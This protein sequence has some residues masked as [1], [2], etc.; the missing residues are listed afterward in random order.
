VNDRKQPALDIPLTDPGF[1]SVENVSPVIE[2]EMGDGRQTTKAFGRGILR[3]HGK[4]LV[5]LQQFLDPILSGGL[6]WG[7]FSLSRSPVSISREL[8]PAAILVMALTAFHL[9]K[10]KVYLSYRQRSLRT[11]LRRITE[12]WINVIACLLLIAFLAK[13][14]T[15]WSRIYFATWALLGWLLM[16]TVHVGSHKGLRLLRSRGGNSRTVLFWGSK[17]SAIEFHNELLSLPYLGLKMTAWFSPEDFVASTSLPQGMPACLGGIKEIENWL[18]TNDVDQIHFN[19]SAEL[20]GSIETLVRIFGNT[21]KP[22]FYMPSWTHPAMNFSIDQLNDKFLIGLWGKD[23]SMLELKLKRVCDIIAS[24]LLIALLSPLLVMLGGMTKL[25]SPGPVLYC[26]DRY[27]LDGHPFKIYKFRTM[28]V[29]EC[30]STMN[31]QQARKNDPRV[32]PVGR[33]M[34]KWSLDELPQLF[35]VLNGSMSLV[36]PRPHAVA[37]NEQ[38]RNQITGYMQRHLFRPGITGLAQVQGFRGETPQLE[39]MI[40]RVEADLYYLKEWSIPLDLRVLIMTLFS[41]HSRNAY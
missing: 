7:V 12:G 36:G 20:D 33:I 2:T 26:Q 4:D 39:N 11:L 6:F 15:D 17:E 23:H 14:T 38:Y 41:L 35:N 13:V 19:H 22:V 30:G 1:S 16:A 29:T 18:Q 28:T 37:H 25:S 32:T 34:R 40:N 27:G 8:I 3:V 9:N 31:L 10:C 5:R 24:L 21:C